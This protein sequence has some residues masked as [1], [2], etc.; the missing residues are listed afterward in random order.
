MYTYTPRAGESHHGPPDSFPLVPHM[1]EI[2]KLSLLPSLL[3]VAAY[4]SRRNS[5]SLELRPVLGASNDSLPE[6]SL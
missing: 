2:E 6:L 1:Q 4:I 3:C 5:L